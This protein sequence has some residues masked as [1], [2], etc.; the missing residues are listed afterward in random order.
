MAET[1]RQQANRIFRIPI[2]QGRELEGVMNLLRSRHYDH[3]FIEIGAGAGGSFYCWGKCI[4]SGP[5]ISVDWYS[6][7]SQDRVE[8]TWARRARKEHRERLWQAYFSE[9]YSVFAPSIGADVQVARHLD[10][11]KVDFLFIDGRWQDAQYNFQYYRRF[12]RSGGL[13]ALHCCLS[14]REDAKPVRD[15]WEIIRATF[16]KSWEFEY[17]PH[18]SGLRVGGTGVVEVP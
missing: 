7:D 16:R 3:G 8:L 18:K 1:I 17:G 13:I 6:I 2:D 10:G 11:R 15:L 14:E 12:V 9:T 5:K 4:P